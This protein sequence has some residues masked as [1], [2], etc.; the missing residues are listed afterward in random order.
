MSRYFVDSSGLVKRYATE[1][2]SSWIQSI[3][4]PAN[5]S[6]VLLSE[7]TRAEVTAALARKHRQPGGISLHERDSAV[8]LF[9]GHCAAEYDLAP[10]TP[11]II[12]RAVMLTQNYPLRG[13]DAV[14]LATALHIELAL[15]SV[16]GGPLIFVASDGDL[17]AAAQG[18]GLTVE[19]PTH[20]P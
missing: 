1:P 15:A 11:A 12:D 3:T 18:E 6:I 13:Y 20:Y 5:G 2:G 4:A 10:V 14:Q 7:I 9:L 8:A 16:S 19:N 17:L